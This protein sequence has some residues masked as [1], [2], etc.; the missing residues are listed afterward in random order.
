MKKISNHFLFWFLFCDLL[1]FD[2]V[3][4]Y[5]M[6]LNDTYYLN[7][8]IA[9]SLPVR[10]WMLWLLYGVVAVCLWRLWNENV[11]K[12]QKL[13]WI[14]AGMVVAGAVGNLI[15]RFV[16]GGVVDFISIGEWFPIF[17]LADVYL[18]IAGFFLLVFSRRL[19][20]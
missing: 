20:K 2:Q 6:H 5:V 10:G 9:F 4:K 13:S 17:N 8:A 18:T 16:Y 19:L 14:V 15:D 12:D 1:I 3:S 7:T 11:Q